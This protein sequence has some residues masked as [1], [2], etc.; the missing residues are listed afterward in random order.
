MPPRRKASSKAATPSA[1]TPGNDHATSSSPTA[2]EAR[3]RQHWLMKAEP[4]PR[5]EKGVDVAFSIDHF[6]ACKTTPWDGVRNPEAKTIMKEKMRLDDAVL[7][8][9]SN[10]KIPGVAGLATV[11]RQ[12]YPD[13]S[14]FDPKHPYYDPK[15]D[16][17]APK[18]FLVDVAFQRRLPRLV[19]LGL[20][21]KIAAGDLS[22]QEESEIEYL[23]ADHRRAIREMALL[24][25]GRLSVQPVSP[26][27]YEA[28]VLLG[29]RGGWQNWPGK[30]NP[31]GAVKAAKAS[32]EA[33]E[34][35]VKPAP[36]RPKKDTAASAKTAP[37]AKP[38]RAA[39]A[40]PVDAESGD[41][42]RRSSRLA[43]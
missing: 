38:K 1:P 12:G 26:E 23:S 15:S 6:E 30:W 18:W 3:P 37:A 13:A 36:P 11:C 10:T 22:N 35:E 9:H 32:V 2:S 42:R 25:R 43:A 7:F 33:V 39:A 41:K 4:D 29:D 14:A 8:Y 21:Q 31:K 20:L 34:D 24:N 28:V 17:A 19:P 5:L 16:P 27:A 40:P